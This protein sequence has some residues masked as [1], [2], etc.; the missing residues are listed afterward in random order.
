MSRKKQQPSPENA[1][2]AET[3]PANAAEVLE[4]ELLEQEDRYLRLAADFDNFRKRTAQE[5]VRRSAAQKDALI[6]EILPVLDNMERALAVD[7]NTSFEQILQGVDMILQQLRQILRH[8][9]V[10]AE[11]ST[12]E[13]FDPSR[14]EAIGS[15]FDPSQPDHTVLETAQKGYRRAQ[16][17]FRP[18]KVIVN[19]HPQ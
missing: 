12:G 2:V 16:E 6:H 4:K 5:T 15:R 19:D 10:E 1:P 11:E 18:A 8:H 9:L 3:S 14:H 17:V 7:A 13:L